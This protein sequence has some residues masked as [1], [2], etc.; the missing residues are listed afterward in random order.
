MYITSYTAI[1]RCNYSPLMGGESRNLNEWQA[2][3]HDVG[4][5]PFYYMSPLIENLA[6]RSPALRADAEHGLE[7]QLHLKSKPKRFQRTSTKGPTR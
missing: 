1:R 2:K 6:Q 4:A 3:A 5:L 7:S